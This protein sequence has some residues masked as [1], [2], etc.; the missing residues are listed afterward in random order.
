MRKTKLNT[1]ETKRESKLKAKTTKESSSFVTLN[2]RNL[3]N[4]THSKISDAKKMVANNALNV[5]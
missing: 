4:Q 2:H 5:S 1:D 3:L